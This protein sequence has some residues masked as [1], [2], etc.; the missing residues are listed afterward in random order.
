MVAK[1]AFWCALIGAVIM[2]FVGD[3][4]FIGNIVT[5]ALVG[6]VLGVIIRKWIFK[7]FW[8]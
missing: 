1:W 4:T 5:G 8:E 7:T 2:I 6:G 3:G